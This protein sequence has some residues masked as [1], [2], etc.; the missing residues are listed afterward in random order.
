MITPRLEMIIKHVRGKKIADIG[1]DH[2][3][4]PIYLIENSLAGYVI[5][6]DI[7]KGP[8][9]I[10]G[11]NIKNHNLTEKIETRLGG[12]LSVLKEN[13]ADT[14]IIAGMGGI[15]ISEI[16]D[17]DIETAKKSNLILQ[18]MNAQYELRKY[19]LS[20]G[21]KITNE[22]IAVEGFKVYNLIEAASGEQQPFENDFE[23]HVPHYLT[24][25][26]YFKNL[27]NKKHR[28]FTKVIK[29]LENS[30]E[31]DTEKLNQYKNWLKELEKYEG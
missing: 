27:Y 5:A 13:E 28:E 14:I 18:P 22:D 17:A 20:N 11:D 10:A 8:L 16:I 21:F 30:N 15:L 6:S 1:T 2:A 4:I 3:Y 31:P 29:G 9:L 19:L 23:Y 24:S 26:K 7:N 12:G 25:H